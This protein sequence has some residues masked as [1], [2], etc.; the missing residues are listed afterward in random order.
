MNSMHFDRILN[1]KVQIE[2]VCFYNNHKKQVVKE[3]LGILQEPVLE[4]EG[5]YQ[6]K[7]TPTTPVGAMNKLNIK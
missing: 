5:T 2:I 3:Y 1:Y 6:P 4:T 7:V